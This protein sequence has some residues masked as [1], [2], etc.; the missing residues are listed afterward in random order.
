VRSADLSDCAFLR[1]SSEAI[2]FA[3]PDEYVH[4]LGPLSYTISPL[5]KNRLSCAPSLGEIWRLDNQILAQGGGDGEEVPIYK[6]YKLSE[7][8]HTVHMYLPLRA[9]RR[10]PCHACLRALFAAG[11]GGSGIIQPP[12]V[13]LFLFYFC[14]S[15]F[16]QSVGL[17][18]CLR[19]TA[20]DRW[21]LYKNIILIANFVC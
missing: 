4:R 8:L 5:L 9:R 13:F 2:S 3:L 16:G 18:I 17:A 12:L 21:D 19:P 10:T 6:R 1:R 11:A 15:G 7:K 14:R 20:I